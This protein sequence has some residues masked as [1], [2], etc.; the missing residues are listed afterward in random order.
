[1]SSSEEVLHL[2]ELSSCMSFRAWTGWF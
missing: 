2:T 1:M